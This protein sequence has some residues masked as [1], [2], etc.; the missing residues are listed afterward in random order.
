MLVEEVES[1]KQRSS[2]LD[3]KRIGVIR[4]PTRAHL[5]VKL[6]SF[7]M[8]WGRTSVCLNVRAKVCGIHGRGYA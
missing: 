2:K 5:V 6:I 4:I 8:A 1:S 7:P 3:R